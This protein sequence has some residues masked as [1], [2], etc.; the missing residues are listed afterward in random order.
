MIICL[1]QLLEILQIVHCLLKLAYTNCVK[2]SV[3]DIDN[4]GEVSQTITG[5]SNDTIINFS[6]NHTFN[7]QCSTNFYFQGIGKFGIAPSRDE[8]LSNIVECQQNS[9]YQHL[10]FDTNCEIGF[11]IGIEANRTCYNQTSCTFS[12]NISS[13]RNCS[14]K[15]LQNSFDFYYLTYVCGS[16]L[17]I[18]LE[19]FINIEYN[20]EYSFKITKNAVSWV[21]VFIDI[22]SIII[23]LVAIYILPIHQVKRY[24]YYNKQKLLVSDFTLHFR[25]LDIKRSNIYEGLSE[26]IDHI[27]NVLQNLNDKGENE[28]LNHTDQLIYDINFPI[29]SITQLETVEK[30]NQLGLEKIQL[31]DNSIANK[32]KIEKIDRETIELKKKL[33]TSFQEDLDEIDDVFITFSTQDQAKKLKDLY[34]NIGA[35]ARQTYKCFGNHKYNSL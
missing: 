5:I 9:Y 14:E 33:K 6:K 1:E 3:T 13:L 8:D 34:N 7:I 26:L 22:G 23:V 30:L 11:N 24:N 19:T 27:E 25:N 32:S 2:T 29:M 12:A 28:S 31:S 20:N 18:I 10:S 17:I 21:V 16:K 4:K 35:C 15:A